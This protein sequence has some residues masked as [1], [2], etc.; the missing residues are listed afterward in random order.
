MKNDATTPGIVLLSCGANKRMNEYCECQTNHPFPDQNG[1]NAGTH[2]LHSFFIQQIRTNRQ[3]R[4]IRQPYQRKLEHIE[5]MVDARGSPHFH[6]AIQAIV[7]VIRISPIIDPQRSVLAVQ[8]VPS[9][10]SNR[11]F[12][13]NAFRQCSVVSAFM[14]VHRLVFRVG[15]GS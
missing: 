9:Y 15:S 1:S 14:A 7:A 11:L 12:G 5:G 6:H 4:L 8:F 13:V 3:T 10:H 2:T